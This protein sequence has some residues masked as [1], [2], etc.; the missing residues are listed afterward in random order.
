MQ[1]PSGSAGTCHGSFQFGEV[2]LSSYDTRPIALCLPDSLADSCH[3]ACGALINVVSA[4]R[5]LETRDKW[6]MLGLLNP[7]VS[8]PS[9]L[10]R[11]T[12][13]SLPLR[14]QLRFSES[15]VYSEAT[16]VN[17]SRV[18]RHQDH[19]NPQLSGC[20][21]NWLKPWPKRN[22]LLFCPGRLNSDGTTK[23]SSASTLKCFSWCPTASTLFP[24]SVIGAPLSLLFVGCKI[25]LCSRSC[26]Q[27]AG[28]F[29]H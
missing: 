18:T 11:I 16:R 10:A 2:F 22:L 19:L 17:M 13:L 15:G 1:L 8:E 7:L 9:F 20:T 4:F 29:S 6:K 3:F 24:R 5:N 25:S 14:V 23:R 27:P 12:V 26:R 21:K 28:D